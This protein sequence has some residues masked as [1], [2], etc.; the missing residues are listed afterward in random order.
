ME[1]LRRR[2]AAGETAARADLAA[3]SLA[4]WS[5]LDDA[6]FRALFAGSPMKR[7]GR[8][9]FVRNV[10]IA[11]GNSGDRGLR[12]VAERL[13]TVRTTSWP[14]PRAGRPNAYFSR[15]ADRTIIVQQ[16]HLTFACVVNVSVGFA[17]GHVKPDDKHSAANTTSRMSPPHSRS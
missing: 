9:R 17:A 7:I 8:N 3:P 10:L 6:G 5:R 2:R 13:R 11:I 12:P 16:P 15:S 1:P 14:R 4:E